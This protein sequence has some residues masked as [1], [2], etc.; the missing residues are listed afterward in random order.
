MEALLL[1]EALS[2]NLALSLTET[3]HLLEMHCPH[4][5]FRVSGK[6]SPFHDYR[7]L[8]LDNDGDRTTF[9]SLV[10]TLE[11]GRTS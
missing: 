11:E 1:N 2:F 10:T 3:C 7:T 8:L 9:D 5:H 4:G 6:K